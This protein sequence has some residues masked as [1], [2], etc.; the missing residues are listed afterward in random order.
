MVEVEVFRGREG[1][2]RLKKDWNALLL[3]HPCPR[4]FHLF[5]WWQVYLETLE[6]HP[7]SVFFVLFR[8]RH[9]PLA[10]IPLKQRTWRFLGVRVRELGFPNHPHMPLQD[11]LY[12]PRVDVH[13]LFSQWLRRSSKEAALPWD[14]VRLNG[15]LSESALASDHANGF[16]KREGP[17]CAYFDCDRPYEKIY[18]GFSKSQQAN[19][20]KARN[21]WAKESDGRIFTVTEPA[22]VTSRF[23]EFLRVEASGWKGADG[24]GTA[25]ALH[26][27]L[28]QFYERLISELSPTG[29]IRLYLLELR[30]EVIAA[31][32]CIVSH[33]T[34]Y[35]LKMGY[36]PQWS[37]LSPGAL[38]CEYILKDAAANP[39]IRHVNCLTYMEWTRSWRPEICK[40]YN[41]IL[42]NST[43]IGYLCRTGMYLKQA[44]T[45][46]GERSVARDVEDRLDHPGGSPGLNPSA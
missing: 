42:F 9:N 33:G 14:V 32:L 45:G 13:A 16:E 3:Q 17:A 4:F 46:R 23:M 30:G 36:D 18:R 44:L 26:S 7:D 10:L 1:F 25:I 2:T 15:V 28:K 12:R 22:E 11:A 41:L 43:P 39:S 19:L 31:N 27:E 5:E 35:G 34:F 8:D 20:R 21:R 37:R 6:P 38:L 40:V 24:S 29:K